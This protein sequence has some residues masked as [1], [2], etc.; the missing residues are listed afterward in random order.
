MGRGWLSKLM[1]TVMNVAP[2]APFF[3]AIWLPRFQLQAALRATP[4]PR[5]MPV[6]VLDSDEQGQNADPSSKE[7]KSRILHANEVASRFHIVP[8][9]T[10]AQA[11]ARCSKLL[12]LHRSV[13]EEAIAQEE[14]LQC[15]MQWTPNY[16]SSRPGL[17]VLDLSQVRDVRAR[18]ES[19]GHDMRCWLEDRELEARIGLADDPDQACLGARAARPVL[20]LDEAGSGKQDWFEKLPVTVLEPS[21]E[22]LEVL[23]LWGIQSLAAFAALS[24][25]DIAA[26]LGVE[27]ALLWDMAHGGRQRLL[28]LVRPASAFKE[29]FEFE[30][31]VE[32]ME[33]LLFMLRRMLGELCAQLAEVW[34]LA[35]A[36]TIGLRFEDQTAYERV[37]HVAEP[38]RDADLLL[39]VLHTHLDGRSAAAPIIAV[40]LEL[41][42]TR[43]AAQQ[44]N[45][46]ERRLRDP[47]QF[48]ETLARLEAL[49]GRGNV[50]KVQLLPSRRPNAFAVRNY[51]ESKKATM[52]AEQAR[53]R[54]SHGLPLRCFRP[55]LPVSVTMEE[56]KP[57]MMEAFGKCHTI[58]EVRGPWR[59]SGDWWDR[60]VWAREIWEVATRDGALYQ[61]AREKQGWVLDGIFG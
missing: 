38:T 28:R 21:P 30:H 14:L 43:P 52:N 44:T 34:M 49:L 35:A 13:G 5:R 8:G 24:R 56:G 31:P 41:T 45:L 6:A 19:A 16:E 37:L 57:G 17:C 39:R 46:F 18:G 11:Q 58:A 54:M 51:L 23:E 40:S 12:L 15:A 60:F 61:M 7:N 10:P 47:N 53:E 42:P 9:M 20:V 2:R 33:P 22:I 48:S 4:A 26:R 36:L 32:M 59:M 1:N 27:G 3:A 29:V 55:A 25:A 50:G